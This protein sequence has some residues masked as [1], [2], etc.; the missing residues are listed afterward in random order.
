ME[1]MG[2]AVIC[3]ALLAGC[4]LVLNQQT[5]LFGLWMSDQP[6][7]LGA[8]MMFY[9]MLAGAADPIRR[10]IDVWAFV[11]KGA[12]AADRVYELFDREPQVADPA[13]PQ[14]LPARFRELVFDD[15]SFHYT[16]EQP[17]LR[18]INLR[19]ASDETVAIVGPNGCGKTTLARMILRFYDPVSGSVRLDG[20]DLR[21]VR[22]A[23]LRRT[24]GLV[25][26]QAQLFDDTV[27]E[28]IR[29]GSP[30]A[31]DD[32]VIEA[33]K[34][35]HAHRFIEEKL[36]DGY[37]TVVGQGGSKLSGGQ[38]QRVALARA[39]LRDPR[40]LLLDEATSQVDLESEQALHQVLSTFV[41]G[42][43]TVLITH[44]L[45]TLALAD[46]IIVM[47]AGEILDVGTHEELSRRCNLYRRLYDIQFAQRSA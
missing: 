14:P 22:L 26:Q 37:Q 31:T 1:M 42:R 35:A 33:A 27:L 17:V 40:I 45:A 5:H 3:C 9:G 47:D 36:S 2:I 8:L 20:T 41:R 16:S 39:I 15:V 7:S 18:G 32:E 6:L 28:N 23:D 12:V 43:L 19:L 30:H 38:R 44:R 34:K 11:Q 10:T 29:Y 25:S 24:I 4:Y 13:D 21:A 46:R